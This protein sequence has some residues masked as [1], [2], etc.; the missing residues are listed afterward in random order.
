MPN[1]PLESGPLFI[2]AITAQVRG[3]EQARLVPEPV[4]SER[5]HQAQALPAHSRQ[6]QERLRPE[7]ASQGPLHQ[8]P[9]LPVRSSSCRLPESWR[10]RFQV[11]TRNK[12]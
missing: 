12:R 1:G 9:A 3:P 2:P 5:S 6:A 11:Q 7:R 8:A 10:Y 4:Q